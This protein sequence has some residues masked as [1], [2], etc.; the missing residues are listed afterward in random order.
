MRLGSSVINLIN[1]LYIQMI[2]AHSI[3]DFKKKNH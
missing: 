1:M 3:S 2:I